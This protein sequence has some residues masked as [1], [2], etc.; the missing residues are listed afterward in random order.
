MSSGYVNLSSCYRNSEIS[1]CNLSFQGHSLYTVPSLGNLQSHSLC[2]KSDIDECADLLRSTAFC[3]PA[4]SQ[5]VQ[6][7]TNETPADRSCGLGALISLPIMTGYASCFEVAAKCL[8][9]F[10][11][12]FKAVP[13][14]CF[15]YLLMISNK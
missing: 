1:P 7:D 4:G 11:A 10:G 13:L 3:L 15:I 14:K 5:P 9:Q 8:P 6:P 12:A 2:R